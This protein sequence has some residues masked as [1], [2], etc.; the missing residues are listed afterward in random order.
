M[1]VIEQRLF[2]LNL[3]ILQEYKDKRM[4]FQAPECCQ[5]NHWDLRL[6]IGSHVL[7]LGPQFCTF[8]SGHRSANTSVHHLRTFAPAG[9]Q[10]HLVPGQQH[11]AAALAACREMVLAGLPE[12]AIPLALDTSA[13]TSLALGEHWST[14]VL[15]ALG[16]CSCEKTLCVQHNCQTKHSAC[17]NASGAR[18]QYWCQHV[19]CQP[20]AAWTCSSQKSINLMPVQRAAVPL[21]SWQ[22]SD[23]SIEAMPGDEAGAGRSSCHD[24]AEVRCQTIMGNMVP[25]DCGGVAW[26]ASCAET[27]LL[28]QCKWGA[29]PFLQQEAS[30]VPCWNSFVMSCC[31]HPQVATCYIIRL[32]YA[33]MG[34]QA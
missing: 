10:A 9:V 22:Q 2:Q 26:N 14:E 31:K 34:P 16:S 25:L 3:L 13:H 29:R 15:L 11:A 1:F 27:L 12:Q 23:S 4:V 5:E 20:H 30:H 19:P 33:E 28:V 6:V 7:R 32:S 8:D 21:L 17:K 18:C 24:F